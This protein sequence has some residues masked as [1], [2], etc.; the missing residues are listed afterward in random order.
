MVHHNIC[1][2]CDSAIHKQQPLH[3]REI[4]SDGVFKA[5]PPTLTYDSSSD[6]EPLTIQRMNISMFDT[7]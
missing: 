1:V 3:D 6:S 4:W 2:V 5:V 7:T